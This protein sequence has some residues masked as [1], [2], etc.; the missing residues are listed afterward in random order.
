MQVSLT[1][2]KYSGNFDSAGE[3][4]LVKGVSLC[5]HEF[6]KFITLPKGVTKI[7]VVGHKQP[8]RDRMEIALNTKDDEWNS[9]I[10]IDGERTEM[11]NRTARR[12][13]EW[14]KKGYKYVSIEY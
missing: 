11:F 1:Y 5:A 13:A 7:V 4:T 6:R 12:A 2:N 9:F 8:G 3:I 10:K 14:I